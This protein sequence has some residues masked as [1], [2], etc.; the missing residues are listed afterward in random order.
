[1]IK[2]RTVFIT[3]LFAVAV[4]LCALFA[5]GCADKNNGPKDPEPQLPEIVALPT[6]SNIVLGE[7]GG[8]AEL[9]G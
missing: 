3:L 1:M 4:L 6:V 2:K 5:I 9:G 8:D 7:I